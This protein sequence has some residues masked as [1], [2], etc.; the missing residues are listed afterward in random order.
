VAPIRPRLLCLL[1]PIYKITV[2]R[3][4]VDL[5]AQG[6]ADELPMA[7]I[8]DRLWERRGEYFSGI[9]FFDILDS[10]GICIFCL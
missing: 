1:T 10:L 8:A 6:L 5:S 3:A 7:Y 2:D 4:Q 9:A